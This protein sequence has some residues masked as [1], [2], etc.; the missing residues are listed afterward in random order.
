MHER[1]ITEFPYTLS[2]AHVCN[3]KPKCWRENLTFG[4]NR[5]IAP[6]NIPSYTNQPTDTTASV[7]INEI[8]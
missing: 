6:S 8:L 7:V 3:I 1:D 5:L 2:F 4:T